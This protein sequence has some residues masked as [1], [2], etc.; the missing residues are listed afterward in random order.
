MANWWGWLLAVGL[1]SLSSVAVAVE[2]RTIEGTLDGTEA[3]LKDGSFYDSYEFE[4]KAGE[5]V[6]IALDS[7]DFDAYLAL[8]DPAGKS[9]AQRDDGEGANARL[10]VTLTQAGRYRVLATSYQ[11]GDKG[12]YQLRWQP[13]T[14][15]EVIH[16]QQ[17]SEADHLLRQGIQEYEAG[18]FRAAIASWEAALQLYRSLQ[19]QKGEAKSLNNLGHAY[20]FLGQYEKS[21]NYHQQSIE[22]AS[23][24]RDRS[25]EASALGNMGL[26]YDALGQYHHALDLYNQSLWL[27]REINNRPVEAAA[28]GNIGSTYLSLGQYNRSIEFYEQYQAI[29]RELHDRRGEAKALHNLGNSHRALDQYQ[30]AIEYYE[31]SLAIKR[32]L[33]DRSGEANS[34]GGLGNAYQS[35]GEYKKAIVFHEQSLAIERAINY[36]RGESNSL[37]SLGNAY[38]AL[39]DYQQAIN[40]YEQHVTIAREI[41]DQEGEASGL[42]NLGNVYDSLGEY[43]QAINY[44]EQSLTIAHEIGHQQIEAGSLGNLGNAYR[45]LEKYQRA[46]EFYQQSL[47]LAQSIGSRYVAEQALGNLGTAFYQQGQTEAAIAFYKQSVNVTESIRQDIRGLDRPLQ[48]SYTDSVADTYRNLANLL[49]AEGR[50]LEAQ[51]VLDLLT[52]QEVRDYN[53][54]TRATVNAQG[55]IEYTPLESKI[56]QEHGSLIAFDQK[57]LDC[58]K[59]NCPD[60]AKLVQQRSE[61]N[62]EFLQT[63]EQAQLANQAKQRNDE[64]TEDPTLLARKAAPIVQQQPGTILIQTFVQNSKEA[65]NKKGKLWLL[66]VAG[67]TAGKVD[68]T[69]DYVEFANTVREFRDALSRPDGDPAKIRQLGRKLYDWLI[70][71]LESELQQNQI[72]HLIF[73]LDRELRY[74]PI[75]ALHDGNQFLIERYTVANILT[76]ATTD[77]TDRRSPTPEGDRLLALGKTEPHGDFDPLPHVKDEIAAIVRNPNQGNG[78]LYPG[79]GYLDRQ[80]TRQVLETNLYGRRLLHI[81]THGEFNPVNASGSYLLL[82]DNQQLGFDEIHTLSHLEG[83]HLAVLSACQTALSGDPVGDYPGRPDGREINSLTY[84][85]TAEGGAKAILAS[86]WNVNDRSTS[87]LM[88]EFYR[89][90]A[91]DP[92]LT[93][94]EALRQAQLAFLQGKLTR[95]DKVTNPAHP[96]YWSPFVLTGN[97]W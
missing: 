13:A 59:N 87:L 53:R 9:L 17:Q 4:G 97:S 12:A 44:H 72:Q 46:I 89:R 36:R 91:D 32:E 55:Q 67:N 80:F 65:D 49:L 21:I 92:K 33:Q 77:T 35:L 7:S 37:S 69:I 38:Y 45:A 25:V 68:R 64:S 56:I 39:G 83:L 8:V 52:L 82:G 61:L 19:D 74:I 23:K 14:I 27:A 75:A 10:V 60:K 58:E 2:P 3:K 30:R 57:V 15:A 71:P 81:A 54:G 93:K 41:N 96:F 48:Q 94:A 43:N 34:L 76:I 84:A 51:D 18:S 16:F 24:I 47:A 63:I 62:R 70:A 50:L 85:F 11:P 73:R 95:S 20:F 40:F 88:R 1:W 28:L 42:G 79:D 78:G 26:A 5:S 86:L 29:T 90:L 31:Q 66:W 22:I 6:A